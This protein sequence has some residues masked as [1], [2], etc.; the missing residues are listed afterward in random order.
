[1][2]HGEKLARSIRHEESGR[3]APAN[4]VVARRFRSELEARVAK[5][6]LDAAGVPAML[7][8]DSVG[9]MRP[10][11]AVTEAGFQLLVRE[12]D[13]ADAAEILRPRPTIVEE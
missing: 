5:T 3:P 4:L 12:E 13:A 1:M 6:A 10:H 9:G 2:D 8:S 7:R 11:L